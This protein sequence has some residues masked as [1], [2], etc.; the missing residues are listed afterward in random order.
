M[1]LVINAMSAR[2]GGGQTYLKNLLAHLPAGAD[3]DI[4]VY[5]P[6]SLPLPQD[7]RIRRGST[8]WP[9]T[10]PILRSV[11]ERYLLR[12]VLVR[13][14]AAVLFCPGGLISTPAPAGCRTATMFRNMTPFDARARAGIPFGL[15]RV[16]NW[17]LER[18]MLRS[19]GGAD[20]TIFISDYA[21]K[22]IEARIRVPAA[23]TIPHGIAEAFRTHDRGV[24]RP[25]SLPAGKYVVYVSKFESYK[26]QEEVVRGFGMLPR[27]L[28]SEV[29]LLLVGET[30]HPSA[31]RVAALKDRICVPGS[32]RILGAIPYADLPAVYHHAEA[33]LFASSCENCPNILLEALA[34]GRPVLSSNV[35]PMPEFGGAGI[36]YF[37]PFDPVDVARALRRILTDPQHAAD[38]AA[39]AVA[40][41]RRFDW[42]DT[43]A[44]TWQTLLRLGGS[45]EDRP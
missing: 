28:Q 9:T 21:R 14:G 12:R 23:V 1:K 18:L 24:P 36:A 5:A 32:V 40:E 34:S 3:L 38:V 43:A 22:V 13:E 27:D 10:N 45:A 31:K 15:Q 19:M 17:L 26:H 29:T 37:S 33:V 6:A 2:L 4:L 39:A 44:R 16:R 7:S 35:S 30:E 8:R 11:W 42:P 20:L 41:S 25:P